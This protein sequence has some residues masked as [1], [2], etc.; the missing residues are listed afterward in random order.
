MAVKLQLVEII[1][2]GPYNFM[3]SRVV[4]LA[5]HRKIKPYKQNPKNNQEAHGPYRSHEKQ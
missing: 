2:I 1:G 5:F 3:I 4:K